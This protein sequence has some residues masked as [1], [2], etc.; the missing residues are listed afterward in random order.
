MKLVFF[1][2]YLRSL[3]FS[4]LC[5]ALFLNTAKNFVDLFGIKITTNWTSK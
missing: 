1:Y 5:L 3:L 2:V 4:N